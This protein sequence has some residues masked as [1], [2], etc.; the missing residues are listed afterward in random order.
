MF[1]NDKK[2]LKSLL[3]LLNSY[4]KIYNVF[5]NLV[6]YLLGRALYSNDEN[7]AHWIEYLLSRDRDRKR[8]TNVNR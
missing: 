4:G 6:D 5:Y 3:F 1:N 8:F 2:K 7:E